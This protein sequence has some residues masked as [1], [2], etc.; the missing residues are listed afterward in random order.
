MNPVS[1]LI[2]SLDQYL[3][4]KNQNSLSR[5]LTRVATKLDPKLDHFYFINFLKS[6]PNGKKIA[7]LMHEFLEGT[8]LQSLY[9]TNYRPKEALFDAV[10]DALAGLGQALSNVAGIGIDLIRGLLG[11]ARKVFDVI[12]NYSKDWKSVTNTKNKIA[13]AGLALTK[14]AGLLVGAPGK[15]LL[16]TLGKK[17]ETFAEIIRREGPDK[18]NRWLDEV[19]NASLEVAKAKSPEKASAFIQK[20]LGV[21]LAA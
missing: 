1:E 18:L 14:V 5:G 16:S 6:Q 10:R 21:K 11:G 20:E 19:K 17:V 12:W 13:Q 7:F 9:K 3:T 2:N 15:L 4:L 8:S